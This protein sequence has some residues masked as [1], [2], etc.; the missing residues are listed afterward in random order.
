M[1]RK[2]VMPRISVALAALV[3]LLAGPL[4][5]QYFGQN[6]VQ[7]RD[8]KFSVLQT[9][10]FDVYY[11]E[12]E[13]QAAVDAARMAERG[14]G[15][16]SRVLNHQYRERQPIILFASHSEFQQ[17]NIS[18][19]SE[20]TGGFTEPFRHRV[21][22]PFTGSYADFDHVLQHEIVHQFQFDVFARGRI[23]GGIGRLM[24]VNPP[25]WF[26][27]GM[28]EYLSVG[29]VTPETAMWLRDAALEGQ[30]PSIEELTFNPNIFPY[31]FGHALLAY[32]G[33]RWGDG[34]IGEILHA[35][36]TAGI[37]DGIRRAVGMSVEDLSEEWHDAIQRTYLPQI[38]EF[39]KARRFAAPLLNQRRSSGTL[40]ISPALSPDGKE[41]AYFSEG[42]SFFIDLYLANG[43][44]GRIK[45]RLIRSAFSSDFE[46]LRFIYSGG[47]WSP[48]GKLFA[49]ATKRGGQDDLVIFDVERRRVHQRLRVPLNGATTPSWSPDGRQ[50]VFTGYDG[51]LS[52]LFVIGVDGS[53][54]TRLTNDRY[55]DLH[56][57]WSPDG[58]TVAFA[59]DRGP[60]ANLDAL[61][62]SPLVI[63]LYHLENGRVELLDYMEGANTNPQ[64]APDGQSIAFV[65]NRTGVANVFLFDLPERAVYQLTNAFT[66]IAGITPISPAISWARGADRLALTYYEEGEYNVYSI[67]NPRALKAV[68]YTAAR[69][70]LV[71]AADQAARD[72]TPGVDAARIPSTEPLLASSVYRFRGGFR[73][74]A[75]DPVTEG[76]GPEPVS[77]RALLDSATLALPD[78]AEFTLKPYSAK[79][80]PDYVIQPSV[81]YQRDNFGNGLFGGTAIS[82][83]DVLANQRIILSGEVN[84]RL[85]E[86]QVLA[87]YANLRRRINWAVGYQQSPI[88]FYS[89][90]R[91]SDSN[92]VGKLST[93]L[94]RYIIHQAFAEAYRPFSR[95]SRVEVGLRATNVSRSTLT[96][97]QYF[98]PG[99]GLIL[100]QDY[101]K[102]GLGSTNYLQPNIALVYDNSIPLWVGPFIGRRHR[103]E[104]SPA[105]GEWRFY[106]FLGDSR[107]Y[108]YLFG[109][110]SFASRLLFFGRFGRDENQFPIFL[111]TPELL[112]GYTAGSFRRFEC[113]FD[114]GGSISGCSSLDQLIGSRIAVVNLELRFPLVSNLT[115]G[116]L[117][118]RLPPIEGAL[119]F[120]AGL[121]WDHRH[122]FGDGIV[123]SRGG[124]E[125]R[126]VV[127]QPL[128]SWGLS[129][130]G[131]LLGFM[132]L[133]ADYARPLDRPG[134]SAYWTLS[135]GPTF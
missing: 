131:N 45:R 40:H 47:S 4:D 70:P 60:G 14:Y 133:R 37:A 115:L 81:G 112:R 1:K 15:R 94:D 122:A 48:D 117:P 107:R 67:D 29:P 80:S 2:A 13:A 108:D 62:F 135:V 18:D 72:S 55:A 44:T 66:G 77:V 26:M 49:I 9:E 123:W 98:D 32:I 84:G 11:H 87:V 116:L 82:L 75:A 20:G 7:Y 88:F 21:L 109:P 30:L 93:S 35:V 61:A 6:R 39:E 95:F 128:K 119:F 118:I 92:G 54:L 104:V 99:S 22:L 125:N 130:R 56:P 121:A 51:G 69:A 129:I 17:N 114:L 19:V 76:A 5:A 127:R 68:P 90:S 53:N 96:F 38:T 111:G 105:F 63:A 101:E 57:V 33:E 64:W 113:L 134:K 12:G 132:V 89:G 100:D 83:S 23:G 52:D 126:D 42:N 50:L 91:L 102:L 74:S 59:T 10:H 16:L 31:R 46:S 86:A 28:A 124:G 103:F 3:A 97:L 106:Q 58:R 78:P 110:F 73:A 120:D 36:A 65:S 71:A 24:A 34:A 79:L 8:L 27:E 43:E 41:V 25:L 85:E